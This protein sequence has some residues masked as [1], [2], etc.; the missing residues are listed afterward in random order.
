VEMNQFETQDLNELDQALRAQDPIYDLDIAGVEALGALMDQLREARIKRGISQAK[1]AELMRT[2]QSAVSD[3]ERS[4]G[5]P[6]V[7]TLRRYAASIGYELKHSV[8]KPSVRS[9]ANNATR[10]G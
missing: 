4:L 9:S 5:D 7:S 8:A 6:R 1:V 3:L 2:T 10:Q